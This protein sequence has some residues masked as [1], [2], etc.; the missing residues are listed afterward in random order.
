MEDEDREARHC[1]ETYFFIQGYSF[2][3]KAGRALFHGAADVSTLGLWELVGTPAE[4]IF[5]GTEVRVEVLYDEQDRVD[6]V[7][8]LSGEK[9]VGTGR[10]VSKAE[11]DRR[12]HEDRAPPLPAEQA[13]PLPSI[14]D[15]DWPPRARGS[16][17]T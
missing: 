2:P 5:D 6:S 7:C 9:V 13:R 15:A 14:G 3:V 17:R 1:H 16:S 11:I 8:V 4:L 12:L 10:I